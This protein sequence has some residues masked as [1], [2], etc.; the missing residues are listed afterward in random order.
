MK[1]LV[2]LLCFCMPLQAE[3]LKGVGL[4]QTLNKS[5]FMTALYMKQEQPS[6]LELR[7]M[8]D[9]LSAFRFRELWL[10]ALAVGGT[11]ESRQRISGEI[12]A[13]LSVMRGPL[14]ENDRVV[15]SQDR[16]DTIVAINYRE[17][18]RLS[19]EFLP[20]MVAALTNR[21]ALVP[22][23]RTALL[24]QLPDD[25]QQSLLR[26][27]DR[28]SPSLGRVAETAR[29]LRQSAQQQASLNTLSDPLS[30]L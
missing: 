24:G 7:I 16:D 25:Q 29:W 5:W 4:F 18:L 1:R 26:S 19:A 28:M 14:R 27:F 9:K 10:D 6:R 30:Q 15:I 13:F 17:H 12:D 3:E 23:L 22:E 20:L 8:E 11:S 21:I 2:L